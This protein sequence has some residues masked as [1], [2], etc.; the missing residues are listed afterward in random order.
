MLENARTVAS[1]Q[2]AATWRYGVQR[3]Q[4][5]SSQPQC[6]RASRAARMGLTVNFDRARTTSAFYFDPRT[7]VASRPEMRARARL[8]AA[9]TAARRPAGA[10]HPRG[11][12]RHRHAAR[13]ALRR[14]LPRAQYVGLETSE[15]LCRRYGW[16]RGRIEEYR[17]RAPFDLVI[18]Y[19]VLQYLDDGPPRRA[20]SPT[21][22]A[23]AAACCTSA[24]SRATT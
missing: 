3:L 20:R 2:A 21:S 9:M 11:R 6:D 16:Q 5:A 14:L 8:I 24:R 4:V 12:L 22:G 13:A 1:A 23:C 10:A 7:A 17:T 19:D 15:Y 18:C